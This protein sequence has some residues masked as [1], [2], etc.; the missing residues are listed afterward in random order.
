MQGAIPGPDMLHLPGHQLHVASC[1]LKVPGSPG[2]L[3]YAGE[4]DEIQG[5][6]LLQ[7]LRIEP[8]CGDILLPSEKFPGAD[9]NLQSGKVG[10]GW[11]GAAGTAMY[12]RPGPH[13]WPLFPCGLGWCWKELHRCSVHMHRRALEEI[14]SRACT[15]YQSLCPQNLQPLKVAKVEKVFSF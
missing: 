6:A 4:N 13:R 1:P 7:R 11:V 14:P 3:A 2:R 12:F 5:P 9:T 15:L 8:Q 10:T